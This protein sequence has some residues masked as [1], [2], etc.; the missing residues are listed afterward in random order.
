MKK[1]LFLAVLLGAGALLASYHVANQ[2]YY[3]VTRLE[4]TDGYTFS[5]VQDRVKSRTQ[6][7]EANDFFLG[8]LKERCAQCRIVYARC[9][10][11]LQGL[12]LKLLMGEPLPLHVVVAGG[13]RM[14][15]EG[16]AKTIRR[17]C[18]D[19]A[20]LIV[21]SGAPSAACAYPGTMRRP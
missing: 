10:R 19:M 12:E 5:L 1:A 8:P 4:S 9:E 14:A 3:P 20:A 7:G 16:P 6:C 18:E 2:H 11:E 15:L 17:D 21:R 13:F